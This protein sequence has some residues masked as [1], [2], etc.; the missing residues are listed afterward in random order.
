MKHAVIGTAGH[1]DHGKSALVMALTGTD[2][3]RLKE[4]KERGITI[5]LGFAHWQSGDLTV[6]FV[7]VPGHERFVK[8][9]LAGAGGI[10]AVVLVVAADE[11]V[12]PQ[13]REHFEI[14]R[15]LR[16][17]AGII[18]LTKA[19]LVDADTQELATIEVREM[20]AGS[21]LESAPILP[22]S[23]KTGLG[24]DAFRAALAELGRRV[25]RRPDAGTV[26]LPIDRAFSV[27]G[28]G[29]VVTGT[30][31]SGT[32]RAEDELVV[33]PSGAPVKVRGIQVHGSPAAAAVAGQ[34]TA[35]NLGGIDL[36]SLARGDT[37]CTAGS[38]EPTRIIDVGLELLAAAKPLR[39]GTRVRFHQG[40]S[41]LLGRIAIST[42][43]DPSGG[44]AVG[45]A[46]VGPGQKAHAR[47]R[48]ESE[49]VLTRGDRFILRA[50]SPAL[51]VAGGEVFDPHPPRVGIRTPNGR[52]RFRLLDP[53]TP[54][55]EG[56]AADETSV[57]LMLR[58]AGPA[59]FPLGHLVS[60]AGL[61]PSTAASIRDRL[62]EDRTAVLIGD[63]LVA[64]AVLQRLGGQVERALAD[65]HRAQPL[66]DGMPREEMRER[67]FAHA[68]PGVFEHV[69]AG[70][71]E[72]K[73]ITSRDRLA[74]ATHAIELSDEDTRARERI[75]ASARE[76]LFTPQSL[77]ELAESAGISRQTVDR[78]V[79]LL[80]RQKELVKL[81]ELVFHADT[82]ARLR[83]EVAEMK[84][85][86]GSR[87]VR[88]DVAVFKARYGVTRK[89]AIPLLE[90]LDRERITRRVGEERIVL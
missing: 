43:V 50:Y 48:L 29:T 58:E 36:A 33:L 44:Q 2:P 14:C 19:D 68:R 89:F 78:V 88:F 5:D 4:E 18:A 71:V 55:P 79:A 21:F 34:R 24:L 84:R 25:R 62:L 76:S 86:A 63:A 53:A 32:L 37:L 74:M 46:E 30:L 61:A 22:V 65:Y 6:A 60:R 16:V 3:D 57:R 9:M 75:T 17:P 51:T 26:R 81:G 80:V 90:Y 54:A 15:M 83:R 1:I 64:A 52:E 67:L 56:R 31:G 35:V 40:T 42:I 10:D 82:L 70:L 85:E 41:E 39:H 45:S 38:L 47:I 72:A 7:D 11:S 23:S 66:S 12:M 77:A 8:N 73:R 28:F 20:V 13:T 59:G 69:L 27:K 49:A 87:E